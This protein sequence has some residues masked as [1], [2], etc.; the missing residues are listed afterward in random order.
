MSGTAIAD[1]EMWPYGNRNVAMEGIEYVMYDFEEGS[2]CA[3]FD[4]QYPEVATFLTVLGT[5][6]YGS[7]EP[8]YAEVG[9]SSC[10]ATRC[11]M[12][13]HPYPNL[14]LNGT[15]RPWIY[16]VNGQC[17]FTPITGPDVMGGYWPGTKARI[18]CKE[19]TTYVSFLASTGGNLHVRLY[20]IQGKTLGAIHYEA[21]ACTIERTG[22]NPSDFTRYE[23]HLPDKEIAEIR[24][25]GS[26]NAW[27]IDDLIVGGALGYLDKPVNYTYV[28]KLAEQLHGVWWCEHALGFD[29]E[30][31]TYAEPFQFDEYLELWNPETKQFENDQGISNPGL[32]LW[33][34]NKDSDDLAGTSLV[35]QITPEKMRK[36]DFKDNIDSSDAQPG[37]VY[38][39]D[40]F[41]THDDI[42]GQDG[43]ADYIGMVVPETPTGMDLI[44]S[45][46]D[47]AND[48]IGV[49]YSKKSSVE[50]SPAFMGYKRLPGVIRGGKNPIPKGH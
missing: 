16:I 36:H 37:D 28:A 46:P 41:N 38:F 25:S 23:V 21:I 1:Q 49:I 35:K 2:N 39:M 15:P 19:G 48:P 30:D 12:F 26:L 24:F 34:Y 33:A 10:G 29:Y 8:S 4:N 13:I 9:G 32:I 17:A 11:K 7:D 27:N 47:L 5:Q 43:V 31:F 6:P 40:Y 42:A 3:P 50:G 44:A 18:V 22:I 20:D 45:Q 14:D